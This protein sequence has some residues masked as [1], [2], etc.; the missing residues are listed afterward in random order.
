VLSG[1]DWVGVLR[2]DGDAAATGFAVGAEVGS[3]NATTGIPIRPVTTA[4]VARPVS[5]RRGSGEVD[6]VDS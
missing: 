1:A 6:T 3:A 5:R 4:A 2:G